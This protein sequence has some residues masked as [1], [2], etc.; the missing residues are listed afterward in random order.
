MLGRRLLATFGVVLLL[1]LA[2][3]GI[4]IWSLAKV[5][6]ATRDAIQEHGVSERLVV[7][8]YRLQAINAERYK[9]MALSSEPEVGEILSADIQATATQYNDLLKQVGERLQDDADRALLAQADTAAKDFAAAVKELVAARD[10]GLTERIRNVYAQ[11]FQ[12]SSAAL[13]AAVARLAQSQR[14]AIDAAGVRIAE[15]SA[16]ARLALVLFGA[17][18]LLLGAV[19]AQWLV[20]SI[21]RPIRAANETAERVASLDLR[22]DIEG[23][24][25][26]E[27]GQMLLALGAMQGA[28]REL[29]LRVRESVQ[30]VRT[31]A[32]DMAQG[33][34]DLSA[35]TEDAAASLQQTAAA[36]EQVMRNVQHA[37]EAA[38]QAEQLAGAAAAVA[39]QGGEVVSQVV[40][41]MQDIHRASHKVADITS[42]IDGIAFQTNILAL[43]AAVEAAR[44]G[45][46][47]RGFAVVASEV[48]QLA[49]RSAAAAR[50]IKGL[51][52]NSVQRIEAGTVL[53]DNA[54]Q[55]MGRIVASIGQV[56]GTVS[57]IT[58][59]TQ[60]QMQDIGQINT[61]VT[62]LDQMTQQNSAMVEASAAASQGLRDQARN[63]DA[64]ISQ[65]V[66]PGDAEVRAVAGNEAEVEWMPARPDVPARAA[67]VQGKRL[68]PV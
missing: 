43:N 10:S 21:G 6:D 61:A 14:A 56:A 11:R 48:R 62:R 28:L 66:L 18:A 63:L 58:A 9:A 44:A 54:G 24:A 4:G 52:D 2:G 47:G 40:H 51:I 42:V 23:H 57:A 53:A 55:T 12:P 8:A 26:D 1:T 13:L 50:E 59:S 30:N 29:V 41:T 34:T 37:S 15:L 17:T 20:R 45:D 32:S 25:R 5:D 49:T 16:S 3:S 36:L 39:A 65:F 38:H 68:L 19:L 35:R 22:Q 27:A 67:R 60:S 31:A 64:L 7:D 33:N 46:A